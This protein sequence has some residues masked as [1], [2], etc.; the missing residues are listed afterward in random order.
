MLVFPVMILALWFGVSIS[1]VSCSCG[2]W[3]CKLFV[4]E[5]ELNLASSVVHLADYTC[6]TV[7]LER[8]K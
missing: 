3:N 5:L 7:S 6:S 4:W 1:A 2:L 8:V